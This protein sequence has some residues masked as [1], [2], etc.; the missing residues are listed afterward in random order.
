MALR[1][2][3]LVIDLDGTLLDSRGEVP[4]A[5]R[6]AI[7]DARAAGMEVIIATGRAWRECRPYLEAIDQ[8]GWA[9]TAGGSMLND[10]PTGRTHQR[11]T[12]ARDTVHAACQSLLVD[13]HKALI[14][15]DAHAT[16]YE[17]L[18]IGEAQLDPASEWWF[19]KLGLEVRHA[20]SL[21]DDAHPEDSVRVGAVARG[22]RLAM[23]AGGLRTQL[24]DRA[25][26][27]HWSAVTESHA[28]GART[29]LL[30]VFHPTVSKWSMVMHCMA[31]RCI[32]RCR[33]AAIGDELNDLELIDQAG[34]GIAMGNAIDEVKACADRVTSG[35]DDQGVAAAIRKI[36]EGE[37]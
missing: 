2:D 17:Y 22:E 12:L 18:L 7:A 15:K 8:Q 6:A 13:R 27:Q 32:D 36:V 5:N 9:I 20:E 26:V 3:M 23:L 19:R 11:R 33:V 25:I 10:A 34:L 30:E 37:W 1:Y 28:T 14:L 16:G 21:L 29:H 4:E 31:E 24:A 35:H